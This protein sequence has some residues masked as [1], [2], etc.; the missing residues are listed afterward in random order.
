MWGRR[1]LREIKNLEEFRSLTSQNCEILQ[2]CTRCKVCGLR[3]EFAR[4]HSL[5]T[6]VIHSVIVN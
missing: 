5:L 3:Y 4:D 6:V 1:E 2:P